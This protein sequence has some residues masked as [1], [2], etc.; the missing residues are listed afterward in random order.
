MEKD[1]LGESHALLVDFPEYQDKILM[2]TATDTEFAEVTQLSNKWWLYASSQAWP[3]R[4]QRQA[5]PAVYA[6]LIRLFGIFG[7]VII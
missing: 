5:L 3:N 6:S 2:L 7:Y 4:A 1:M